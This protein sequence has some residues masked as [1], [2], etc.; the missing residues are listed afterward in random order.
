MRATE[1]EALETMDE[2]TDE[3]LDYCVQ[4]GV[5]KI[6]IVNEPLSEAELKELCPHC[7]ERTVR[8]PWPEAE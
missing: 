6:N 2:F 8:V 7:G 4:H 5:K 1:I 3:I